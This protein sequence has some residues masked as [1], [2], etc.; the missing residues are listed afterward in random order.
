MA[1]ETDISQV[2][3]GDIIQFSLN[4][5]VFGH[6]SIIVSVGKNPSPFN[7]LVAAH[8]YD[9]DNYPLFGYS[10]KRI[11]FLHITHVNVW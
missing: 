1:V 8:T 7:I 2:L 3:P 5:D 11:R 6:S 4:G 10:Y 9:V